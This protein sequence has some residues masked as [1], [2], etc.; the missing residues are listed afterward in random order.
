MAKIQPGDGVGRVI[1]SHQKGLLYQRGIALVYDSRR[2]KSHVSFIFIEIQ[3]M[4]RQDPS[5]HGSINVMGCK[6]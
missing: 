2:D 6:K 4:E 1:F 5:V 3:H